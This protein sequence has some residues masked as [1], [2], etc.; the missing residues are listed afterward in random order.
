MV[1]LQPD[2]PDCAAGSGGPEIVNLRPSASLE[3]VKGTGAMN[4]SRS[5]IDGHMRLGYRDTLC[6]LAP[7][8]FSYL[9]PQ[10][11]TA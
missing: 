10:S 7:A 3:P 6:A 4:F 11:P 9:C 1:H 8:I 2:A 5:A